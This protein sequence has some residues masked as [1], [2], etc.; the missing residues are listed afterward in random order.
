MPN[1][2][3]TPKDPTDPNT[4]AFMIVGDLTGDEENR[5]PVQMSKPDALQLAAVARLGGLEGGP[6]RAKKLTPEERSEIA[7]KAA[8]ARWAKK[9]SS[10]K[11]S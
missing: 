3:K 9:D 11:K 8:Q 4:L 6:A 2:R 5:E 10:E 7:R 1:S